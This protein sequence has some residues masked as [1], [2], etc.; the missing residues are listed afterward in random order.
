MN[1]I[2]YNFSWMFFNV[3]LAVIPIFLGWLFLTN[4]NT[5]V[6]WLLGVS[7]LLFLP[8]SIYLFTDLINLMR[9]WGRVG[10]LTQVV[11]IFQYTTLTFIG[12]ITFILSLYPFEKFLNGNKLFEKNTQFILIVLNFVIGFGITLGRVERVHSWHVITAPFSVIAASLRIINS[13]E[14]LALTL[15]FG[16]FANLIYFSS[17]QYIIN[18]FRTYLNRVGAKQ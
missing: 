16:L 3:I 18:Y 8:N 4:K 11:F 14:L 1:L 9:Q 7:W 12:L 13:V 15:L 17:K 5:I 6:K 2:T 10:A